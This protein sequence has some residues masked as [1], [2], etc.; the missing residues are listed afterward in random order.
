MGIRTVM[1]TGDNRARRRRSRAKLVS[2]IF[3]Q[4]RRRKRKCG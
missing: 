3:S 1:I 4:K 2:M